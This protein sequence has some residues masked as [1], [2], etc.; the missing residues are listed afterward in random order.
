MQSA[1]KDASTNTSASNAAATETVLHTAA[2][3]A[4]QLNKDMSDLLR[5]RRGGYRRCENCDYSV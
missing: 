3:D 2:A 4:A 5:P 1:L